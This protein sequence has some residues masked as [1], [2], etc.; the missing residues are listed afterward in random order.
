MRRSKGVLLPPLPGHR[1][2]HD[3]ARAAAGDAARAGGSAR[4]AGRPRRRDLY[5]LLRD[6]V[7]DGVLAP[8]EPLP[9]SRQAAADYGVSRGLV[10]VVFDQ[11][12]DEGFLVRA[13]GRG[14][15]VAGRAAG[16][17]GAGGGA[18]ARPRAG[19]RSPVPSRR[20][21][22]YAAAALCREPP[23]PRP[24]NAGIA[25]T[26]DFPWRTWLRLQARAAR[27]TGR[28]LLD[29][30]DPRGVPALRAAIARHLAQFRA[31]RCAPEQVVVFGSAQ[32]ALCALAVLLLDPGDAVLIEDPGYPGARAA[33][34]LA[35]AVLVPVPVDDEGMRVE[36]GVEGARG[37]RRPG[38]AARLAYVTPGHQYPTGAALSLDRRIALLDWAARAGAWIVEDDYDGEFRYGGQP[39]TP[40][41]ALDAHARVVY[42]GTLSKATFVS[43]RLAYAVVP[44]ALVEPLANLRTQIDGFTP[45]LPQM[46][47]ALFMEEGRLASHLRRMR[48]AYGAKRAALV[49]GLAPLGERGWTWSANP[50]G[51]HLMVRHAS[52]ERVRAV[53][54]ASDLDLA[55]LS[56]YRL[57]PGRDDGLFLRFGGLGETGL[58]QG[59]KTL[60]AAAGRCI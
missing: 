13:V 56:R 4:R 60:R 20:G 47:M 40:L 38:A 17:A 28:A 58:R 11:M 45:A 32:Q 46:T 14:T 53:T 25:D 33:F 34:E 6:A 26:A 9:S 12:V 50:A 35:G 43:L 29:A 7:L 36:A 41:R 54:R 2:G 37:R 48:A 39:L 44:N 21:R 18:G 59:L 16:I 1:T 31:I 51:M 8:G 24:F 57:A 15:F 22:A 49:E 27:A 10:E 19:G 55:L 42:L 5:A 30:A 23:A 52:G 3:G